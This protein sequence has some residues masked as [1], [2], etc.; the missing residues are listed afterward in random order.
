MFYTILR[1]KLVTTAHKVG[2]TQKRGSFPMKRQV[3]GR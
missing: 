1:L 2:L 3:W